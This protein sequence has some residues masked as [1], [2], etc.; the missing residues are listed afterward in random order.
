MDFLTR[1]GAPLVTDGLEYFTLQI[2]PHFLG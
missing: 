2:R 1:T